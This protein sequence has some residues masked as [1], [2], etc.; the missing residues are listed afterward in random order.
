MRS[1]YPDTSY[2]FHSLK[3]TNEQESRKES[4]EGGFRVPVMLHPSKSSE[5]IG[6]ATTHPQSRPILNS[7]F[8]KWDG[9][10]DG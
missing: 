10:E 6:S 5:T 2:A 8:Y 4:S 3:K 9:T 1:S 7:P